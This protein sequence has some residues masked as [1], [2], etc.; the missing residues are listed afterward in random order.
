MREIE[1]WT[2]FELSECGKQF[3]TRLQDAQEKCK[4][5]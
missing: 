2:E 1:K 5:L 4:N 3:K